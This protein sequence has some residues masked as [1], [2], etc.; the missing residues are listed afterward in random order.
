MLEVDFHSHTLFS[1]CGLHTIVEMLGSAKK[2]GL[3][4]LAI[5]DHGTAQNGHISSPFFDRLKDPVEGIRL[6]KGQESNVTSDEGDIDFPVKFL[7]FTNVVLLGRHPKVDTL[8]RKAD[9]TEMLITA[10]YKNPYIDILT[11]LNDTAYPVNFDRVTGVARELGIAVESTTQR[12]STAACRPRR[13]RGS[14]IHANVPAAAPPSIATLTRFTKW[15]SMNQLIPC[16]KLAGFPAGLIVNDNARRAFDFIEERR[17]VK[18][19]WME[20]KAVG[21]LMAISL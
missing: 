9:Y 19:S 21:S 6:L 5:T 7:K 14:L 10:M 11:H 8:P 18:L 13:R 17:K 12:F 15:G 20:R 4:A 16:W 1:T 3:K 2:K